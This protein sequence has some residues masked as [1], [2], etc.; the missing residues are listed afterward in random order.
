MSKLFI[1]KI[2]SSKRKLE[3]FLHISRYFAIER[4][5]VNSR[6][7]VINTVQLQRY[8]I[9]GKFL[10]ISWNRSGKIPSKRVSCK[11]CPRR[12]PYA[13]VARIFTGD[14]RSYVLS[15]WKHESLS[16]TKKYAK[17]RTTRLAFLRYRD[18][19]KVFANEGNDCEKI[20]FLTIAILRNVE[21]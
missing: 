5:A 1:Y 10:E 19:R 2:I 18:E 14:S 9:K 11:L 7:S 12:M 3:P 20:F 6:V 16:R 13:C 21:V 17:K 15:T 4:K 8:K